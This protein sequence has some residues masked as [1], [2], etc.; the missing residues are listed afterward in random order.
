MGRHRGGGP[1]LIEIVTST[2]WLTNWRVQ[3]VFQPH[4][5]HAMR[6]Q[7]DDSEESRSKATNMVAAYDEITR[8]FGQV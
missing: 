8:R 1:K 2:R 3:R 5:V 7:W 4:V 6:G